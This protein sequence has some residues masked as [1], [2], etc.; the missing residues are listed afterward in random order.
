MSDDLV[1][2]TSSEVVV[3]DG[4]NRLSGYIEAWLISAKRRSENT[5]EAYRRDAA[6]FAAWCH[7]NGLDV[8]GL[9]WKNIERYSEWLA[10][11]QL[12]RNAYAPSTIARK[13]AALSSFYRWAVKVNHTTTNPVKEA[14]RP[15][16][17]PD[18]STTVKISVEEA[19]AWLA[20]AVPDRYFD[21]TL[22]WAL[23]VILMYLG[24][25]VTEVCDADIADLGWENGR[26]RLELNT[27]GRKHNRRGLPDEVVQAIDMHLAARAAH[28]GVDPDA[29][30]GPLLA[31]M[32]GRRLGR[33][34]ITRFV[35][36]VAK[37][38]GLP[39]WQQITPHTIRHA[40]AALARR[41]G[42]TLEDQQEALGHVDPRTTMRYNRLADKVR[43]DAAFKV[44]ILLRAQG[45]NDGAGV[46]EDRIEVGAAD[47][48]G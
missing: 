37:R 31:H 11:D 1:P 3:D 34:E 28:A 29:L 32:D 18:H 9:T 15:D 14:D 43:R 13:L 47:D 30:S 21:N 23:A 24:P 48:L 41:G 10:T 17:D 12:D 44:A 39:A 4:S 46:E 35:R 40:F 6:D 20:A 22:A 7:A 42:A 33:F 26:R 2:V 16:V 38:A 45:A 25:R 19:E 5:R 36:R 27:K 8:F